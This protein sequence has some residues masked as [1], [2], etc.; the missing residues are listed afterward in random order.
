M[1]TM[2][3]KIVNFFYQVPIYCLR[4]IWNVIYNF[5]PYPGTWAILTRARPPCAH[6]NGKES[7][8]NRPESISFSPSGSELAVCNSTGSSVTFYPA[9]GNGGYATSHSHTIANTDCL[10]Y[11]HDAIISPCDR[12]LI[13][14]ARDVHTLSVFNKQEK[15]GGNKNDGPLWTLAGEEAKLNCPTSVAMHPTESCIAVAN[16]KKYGVV[17]YK[18]STET[19]FFES[20]PHQCILEKDLSAIGLA[21]P[22]GLD[23]SPKGDFLAVAHKFLEIDLLIQPNGIFEVA[24]HKYFSKSNN[25]EG[26][27]QSALA[28]FRYEDGS[29]I[30]KTEPMAISFYGNAE[31][32][33]VSVHPSLNL[34]AVS[35]EAQGVDLLYYAK[36]KG[37]LEL[38]DSFSVFRIGASIKGVGFTQDG[39]QVAITSELNEVLFFDI[40]SSLLKLPELAED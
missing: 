17:I 36:E 7:G 27:G 5:V 30:L 6:I 3:M 12:Y 37:T 26:K 15:Q 34:L 18:K 9:L 31:L 4:R 40:N 21:A 13:A 25:Q 1:T 35:I 39:K 33:S 16:R 24:A 8:L 38:I 28:V 20:E 19:G 10:N 11:V 2:P 32:H 29:Q 23:F 22:H 14:V